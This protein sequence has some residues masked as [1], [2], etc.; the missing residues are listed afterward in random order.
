MEIFRAPSYIV[1]RA[2]CWSLRDSAALHGVIAQGTAYGPV[3]SSSKKIA[4]LMGTPQAHASL[5]RQ[6]PILTPSLGSDLAP[7]PPRTQLAFD[8]GTRYLLV[9]L[10]P[11]T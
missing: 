1:I 9:T 2:F 11:G 8:Y 4:F 7:D 3:G 6:R 10:V 5:Q